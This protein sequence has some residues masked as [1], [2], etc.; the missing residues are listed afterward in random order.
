[1]P[2]R[3][4]I[5]LNGES[6]G[7]S[8]ALKPANDDPDGWDKFLAACSKKLSITVMRLFTT[9]GVGID[10]LEEIEAG[11]T[12]YCS[13]GDDFLTPGAPL[14]DPSRMGSGITN[15][16]SLSSST[17]E[18]SSLLPPSAKPS[19]DSLPVSASTANSSCPSP[20]THTWAGC[21]GF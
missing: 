5:L 3:V 8:V 18:L 9:D 20:G 11:E 10:A 13:S 16:S 17:A 15:A 6:S 12:L 1:M 21:R 4:K 7:G 2:E 19:E 14:L